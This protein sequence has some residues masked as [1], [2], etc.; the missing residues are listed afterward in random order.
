M[1]PGLGAQQLEEWIVL[2]IEIWNHRDLEWIW[3][4][5]Y[6]RTFRKICLVDSWIYFALKQRKE[7]WATDKYF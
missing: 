3:G 2:Q 7:V 5:K 4:Q 1:I 6:S